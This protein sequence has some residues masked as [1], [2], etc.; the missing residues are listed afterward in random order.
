MLGL[1]DNAT[2]A[3]TKLRT[4]RIRLIVTL[5]VSGLLFAVLILA[6]LLIRGNLASLTNFTQDGFASRFL[7]A[8]YPS[9]GFD[10]T[11][12]PALIKRAE[13]IQKDLIARKTAEAK[14]LGVPYDPASEPKITTQGG[15]EGPKQ[16]GVSSEAPAVK[17]ALNELYP[18]T[19][20]RRKIET[21]G[22]D[23]GL[24][25]I[26]TGTSFMTGPTPPQ[27]SPIFEGKESKIKQYFD[28][29]GDPLESFASSATTLDNSLLEPFLLE[30]ANLNAVPGEAIPVLAPIN[31]A[32]KLLKI[33]PLTS[34]AT[35]GEKLNRL[36][37]LRTKARDLEFSACYRNP[38]ALEL[39]NLAKQQVEEAAAAKNTPGYTPPKVQY[40]EAS[41][42]CTPVVITKD[43]RTAEEKSADQKM[44]EFEAKFGAEAP[45]TAIVK[46]R[47]VGLLPKVDY[48]A[49]AFDLSSLFT[50][51]V[52]STLG[53][54]WYMSH[55]AA[56][57]DPIMGKV[58][59]KSA[60]ESQNGSQ[61]Y[62]EFADRVSQ[63]RFLDE[64]SCQEFESAAVAKC[65]K[66]NKFM[67]APYGNPLAAIYDNQQ[68][69]MNFLNN[70]VLVITILSA[71][72]MMGTVG[73]IIADS[74]KETSVFRAVGAKRLD[75]A[76]IYLL[77]AGLLSALAFVIALGIGL[78]AALLM[79]SA[80][81]P[82]LSMQ[83]VLAFNSTDVTKTY[84]LIGLNVVDLV[85]ILGVCIATG[86][87]SALIPLMTNLR[88]N[89]IKDM[90]EE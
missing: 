62:A 66:D 18:T 48:G 1:R 27:L 38:E 87:L 82:D 22:K 54:G 39:Q 69:F 19:N 34:K 44:D 41:A 57:A 20:F 40:A 53:S 9:R 10:N 24:K 6:S 2:L 3:L 74:R 49:A 28:G 77:Y 71:I 17:Q 32:E 7:V 4:R 47:I 12:D 70:V 29:G 11:F 83:A 14:R 86:L 64:R 42:V 35:P 80:Y 67:M 33:T 30:G 45:V 72:I 75:I 13:T 59:A 46:F 16:V 61:Y 58:L 23:Y 52:T 26:Y 85:Q 60:A 37:E 50:S 31:S 8:V 55:Q 90:R 25:Y 68:D 73:K 79:N 89:P 84:H 56:Q 51:L 76:Q 43:S 81:S 36:K 63:K 88:R 15:P 78:G 65:D 5:I 21:A